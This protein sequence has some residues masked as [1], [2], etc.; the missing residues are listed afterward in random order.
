MDACFALAVESVGSLSENRDEFAKLTEMVL[1]SLSSEELEAVERD[2]ALLEGTQGRRVERV[3]T[4]VLLQ[5]LPDSIQCKEILD[6]KEAERKEVIEL[7]ELAKRHVQFLTEEEGTDKVDEDFDDAPSPVSILFDC[8]GTSPT[9]YRKR[10]LEVP[11]MPFAKRQQ[12]LSAVE[13][14]FL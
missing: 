1:S 14:S 10:S 4:R 9:F 7:E 13:H 11:S 5:N 8:G 12:S 2:V 3:S 6:L